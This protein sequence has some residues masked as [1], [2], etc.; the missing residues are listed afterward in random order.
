MAARRQRDP[1]FGPDDV[2]LGY[3]SGLHGTRGEVKLYLYN[4]ASDL[5]GQAADLVLVPPQGERV[6]VRMH[7]RSGAGR[8]ILGRIEGLEDREEARSLQGWEL[9]L[10]ASSLPPPAPGEWYHR[11]LL[12][13]PVRTESGRELG[14]IAEIHGTGEVDIW[15]LR[16]AGGSRYLPALASK[17]VAVR[18]RAQAGQDAGVVVTDDAVDERPPI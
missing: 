14:R 3:V 4:P 2:R 10:P 15:V 8:R 1:R 16:G 13:L 11:D 6:A 5:L 12:G 18:T 17:L 7:L 9:V